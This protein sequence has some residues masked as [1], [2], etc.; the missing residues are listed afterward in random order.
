MMRF[1][2]STELVSLYPGSAITGPA[3]IRNVSTDTRTLQPGDAYVALRG[4]HFDGHEFN[5][6]A[7]ENGASL[8]VVD[9]PDTLPVPQWIVPDT[10]RALGYLGAANR[11]L[12]K[13]PVV[14]LT[15]SSGKTTTKEM[16]AVLLNACG[17]TL[18]TQGNLN[19][20]IGVPKTLLRI[21]P[22]HAYAVVELGANHVGE[23]A[24]T[25]RLTKPDVAVIVNAGTAHLAEFGSTERIRQAKG[26]I[27]QGLNSEGIAVL[28]R[29][30][31]AYEL[32]AQQ[33][34]GRIVSFGTSAE[35][36]IQATCLKAEAERT[37]VNLRGPGFEHVV[38]LPL[39]GAH[40]VSNL[41]AAVAVMVALRLPDHLW[42][43]AIERMSAAPG[44]LAQHSIKGWRLIDDAYNANPESV[45]A[46]IDVLSTAPTP[47]V[48][49]LGELGELGDH[50]APAMKA[51]GSYARRRIAALWSV[52]PTAAPA[53]KA[54]GDEGR[55]FVNRAEVISA[56]SEL[57]QRES[58]GSVLVKGSRSSAMEEVMAALI[59]RL[60][61]GD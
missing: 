56:L 61:K 15:G 54:F 6:V 27:L 57:V 41:A 10:R 53:S 5:P 22:E 12:T 48:L 34:P 26:E 29:D 8:L 1:L 25:T 40:N 44:R 24:Y 37:L 11:Q 49:V 4:A 51:L 9:H 17:N 42:L 14:A 30:D 59:D 21:G 43:D 18:A 23:I 36:E 32:W 52:G 55:H 47:Q 3:Q 7:H 20:E 19:N 60:E 16:L 13:A 28:N 2:D 38:T 33:A 45:R 50:T 31:P 39:V 35:A 58:G 46:A